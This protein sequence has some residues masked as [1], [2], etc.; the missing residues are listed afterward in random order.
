LK[1]DNQVD[2]INCMFTLSS[3]KR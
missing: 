3:C 2:K 1:K